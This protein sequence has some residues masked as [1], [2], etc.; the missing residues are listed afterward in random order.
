MIKSVKIGEQAVSLL[1]NA[2]TPIRYKQT[3]HEDILTVI[4]K[5]GKMERDEV[6]LVETAKQLA[7]VMH[8]QAEAKENGTAV[9]IKEDDYFEWLED[10]LP[11]DFT[12]ATGEIM[13]VYLADSE[14]ESKSKKVEGQAAES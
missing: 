3:F 6:E 10:F 13:N 12:K 1:V 2:T 9:V 5:M 11:M 8:K 7:F 4:G 14:S